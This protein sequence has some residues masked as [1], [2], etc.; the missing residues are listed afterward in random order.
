MNGKPPL[1]LIVDD[2]QEN[3]QLLARILHAEGYR[4][5]YATTG[6][7]L[8]EM[9]REVMP[10]LILMD[11]VM[12]DGCGYEVCR[13]LKED[14]E[15]REIPVIFISAHRA[16]PEDVVEG[17]AVG[18]ADYV[19]KPFNTSELLA[20]LRINLELKLKTAELRSAR[21]ELE[22][23]VRERTA[24]LEKINRQLALENR[25]RLRAAEELLRQQVKLRSLTAELTL[26]EERERRRIAGDIHD[27]VGQALAMIKI[28]LSRV[29]RGL[30]DPPR[31]KA[32]EGIIRYIRGVIKETREL[33][34]E[35]SSPVLYEL[36]LPAAVKDHIEK[37]AEKH[38]LTIDLNCDD[39]V[40]FLDTPTQIHLF[41][42]IRELLFNVLKHAGATHAE[43]RISQNGG[44]ISIEV[45]DNGVG[46]ETA[47]AQI[48][49]DASGGFGLF[50]IRERLFH[51]GGEFEIHSSPGGGT[52]VRLTVPVKGETDRGA[53]PPEG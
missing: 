34:Y 11:I 24:E 53:E 29:K 12:P 26:S 9:A 32:I 43:V 35:L 42:S 5:A 37:I 15:I 21:D 33:S 45:Q 48:K 38:R 49:P 4:I 39:H 7:R 14:P 13:R 30:E 1:I 23:R 40:A 28:D 31:V 41:R 46:F 17:F 25:E 22:R 52:L 8:P 47:G 20:R 36:G 10:D 3:I 44:R 19:T 6:R 2:I 27:S 16:T 50:S 18:G 51:L